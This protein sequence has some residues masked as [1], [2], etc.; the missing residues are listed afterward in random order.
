M[1]NLNDD[2]DDSKIRNII[3]S[4]SSS[5]I[6]RISSEVLLN[7]LIRDS[8]QS[9]I[10]SLLNLSFHQDSIIR[11]TS[12]T[13]LSTLL[14]KPFPSTSQD[15]DSKIIY[16][17]LNQKTISTIKSKLLILLQH[18]HDK[19]R[20]ERLSITNNITKLAQHQHQ[21]WIQL[22]TTLSALF[23]STSTTLRE[24]TF[25]IYQQLPSLLESEST[26]N[27]ITALTIGLKDNSIQLQLAALEASTAIICQAEQV[28]QYVPLITTILQ[29]IPN[30][31]IL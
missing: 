11:L 15:V 24:S 21:P 27:I 23:N 5:G 20:P 18:S 17:S 13:L 9:T 1:N 30:L 4:L 6:E 2:D 8:T 26:Q 3:I 7:N 14:Y 29:V 25:L 31:S 28:D 12:L 16:Q 19:T 22:S 10:L